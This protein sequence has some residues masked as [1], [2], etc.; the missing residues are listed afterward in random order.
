MGCLIDRT[1]YSLNH[2]TV[3]CLHRSSIVNNS[4][5]SIVNLKSNCMEMYKFALK[6]HDFESH[7][8]LDEHRY[9]FFKGLDPGGFQL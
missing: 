7:A 5:N 2:L 8:R 1:S 9:L 6:R 4:L 3:I